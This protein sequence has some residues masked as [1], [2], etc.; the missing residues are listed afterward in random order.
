MYLICNK[1]LSDTVFF[2]STQVPNLCLNCVKM[3]DIEI[4]TILVI[5][6]FLVIH[7]YQFVY[8]VFYSQLIKGIFSNGPIFNN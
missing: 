2:G 5:S 6:P 7:L 4:N 3:T 1:M 8:L